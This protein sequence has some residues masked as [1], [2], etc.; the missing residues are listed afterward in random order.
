MMSR[1]RGA[2]GGMVFGESKSDARPGAILSQTCSEGRR[3]EVISK[4]SK[5][6]LYYQTIGGS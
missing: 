2:I 4:Y 1:G 6:Q 3:I 5:L